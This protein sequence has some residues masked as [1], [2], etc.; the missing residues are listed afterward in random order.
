[1]AEGP[2]AAAALAQRSISPMQISLVRCSRVASSRM[3]QRWMKTRGEEKGETDGIS[4]EGSIKN[5]EY[6]RPLELSRTH[7]VAGLELQ[8]Q[9]AAHLRQKGEHVGVQP[10]ALR[11]HVCR[12]G[13][14]TKAFE[15]TRRGALR[16]NDRG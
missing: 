13:H 15:I 6:C 7:H 3:P 16:N 14:K 9:R 1:M 10:V 2:S 12:A 5:Y 11:L 4:E 8:P